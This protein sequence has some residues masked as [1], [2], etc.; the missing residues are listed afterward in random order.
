MQIRHYGLTDYSE[1]L[2]SMMAFTA[3]REAS[4][5]A[6][7]I[8]FLEHHP[9]YTQGLRN[10][11]EV[12]D[13][14]DGIPLV[15]ANRGGEI[16][17]HGPGQLVVYL[18][19]DLA[20]KPYT[21]HELVTHIETIL[22]SYLQDHHGLSAHGERDARGVYV[23]DRK[24]ASI[25]LRASK[26]RFCYHGFSLNVQMDLMPFTRID[27]CGQKGLEMTQITDLSQHP[28]GHSEVRQALLTLLLTHLAPKVAYQEMHHD[29]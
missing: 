13:A 4:P 18:L 5:L 17:Y 11:H 25:G 29:R 8:W 24:I 12:R 9:V 23:G 28:T 27:P 22:C 10:R 3:K 16:T 6:D 15:C 21:V 19:L 1:M 2:E 14:I 26:G 20:Q 7:E